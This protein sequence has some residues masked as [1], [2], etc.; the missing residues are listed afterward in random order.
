MSREVG[1]DVASICRKC[2]DVWHVI[3]AK[4]GDTIAK[5]EC[6]ECHGVHRYKSPDADRDA[7]KPR[8]ASAARKRTSRA[9]E[10]AG[11]PEQRVQPDMSRP[12]RRYSFKESFEPGDRI[13]HPK[14][15]LGVVETIPAPGRMTVFFSEGPKTLAQAKP[16]STLGAAPRSRFA[17]P[18]DGDAGPPM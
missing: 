8:A 4:V 2:G 9:T 5:V 3:V 18:P 17:T 15:G 11:Q 13:E 10:S 16:E 6:K 12:V 7:A 14:F 1:A